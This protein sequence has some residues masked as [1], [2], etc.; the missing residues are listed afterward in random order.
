MSVS[1]PHRYCARHLL[2]SITYCGVLRYLQ[3]HT[4][5]HAHAP[6]ADFC[7]CCF[8]LGPNHFFSDCLRAERLEFLGRRLDGTGYNEY[9]RLWVLRKRYTRTPILFGL[10]L[11]LRMGTKN[12]LRCRYC[13][14]A[15]GLAKGVIVE[16]GKAF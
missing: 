1:T 7:C 2:Q 3:R 16:T 10:I 5:T 15:S 8:L 13:C 4:H 11:L 9:A 14:F 6:S 12:E